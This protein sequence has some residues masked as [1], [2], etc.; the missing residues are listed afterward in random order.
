MTTH[1]DGEQ[2]VQISI[3]QWEKRLAVIKNR[4]A[5]LADKTRK[6]ELQKTFEQFGLKIRAAS[7]LH[8]VNF[9]RKL[10][11]GSPIRSIITSHNTCIIRKSESQYIGMS[12]EIVYKATVNTSNTQDTKYYTGM[13]SNT[14]KEQYRNHIKSFTLKKYS[15]EKELSKHICHLKKNRTNFTIKCSIIKKSISYTGGSKRSN[16]C[17]EEKLSILE[18]IACS[19]KDRK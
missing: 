2:A 13:T 8:V 5:R 4:S 3:C 6:I 12:E 10:T 19:T 11:C 18:T 16:L 14:F 7:N 1:F 17:L 9:C 15:N